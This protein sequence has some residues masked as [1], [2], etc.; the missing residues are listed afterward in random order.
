MSKAQ[1][2]SPWSLIDRL[3]P[4]GQSR[5]RPT[6]FQE[7]LSKQ[8]AANSESSPQ[9]AETAKEEKR[10]EEK[11]DRLRLFDAALADGKITAARAADYG[12]SNVF[13]ARLSAVLDVV[14][15][16]EDPLARA[17]LSMI[18]VKL[19]R[20]IANPRHLDSATD[21]AGYTRLLVALED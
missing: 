18:A 10:K 8:P 17:A 2:E 14:N 11:S 7:G 9:R 12:D 1:S 16:C 3:A 4:S 13:Y 6:I 15:D 21:L 5:T 20:L 19:C